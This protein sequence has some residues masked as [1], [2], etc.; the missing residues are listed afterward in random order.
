MK[1]RCERDV[2]LEAFNNAQRATS[3]RAALPALSGIRL[4][5]S[6]DELRVTGSDLDLTITTRVTVSGQEDGEVVLS[7]KLAVDIIRALDPGAVNIEASSERAHISS[8]RSNF[9]L[10]TR[11]ADEYP[12]LADIEGE[13]MTIAAQAFEDGLKQVVRA[14]SSDDSRPILT[15]VL[16]AAEAE[17][18]RMVATDS[19]RLAVR[20]LPSGTA[21]LRE[22]ES[23]L[24]PSRALS[25]LSR[26]MKQAE[27]IVLVLG[28]RDASFEAGSIRLTT[29]LIEGDFPNYRGLI[30]QSQP[31]QLTVDRL[32]FLDAVRRVRLMA[33]EGSPIRVNLSSESVELRATNVEMGEASEAV[34]A[35][36]VG[37]EITVAFNPDYLIDGIEIT[38]G[39]EITLNTVDELKP[40]LIRPVGD[41]ELLYLLMPVRV[42]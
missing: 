8:G 16:I 15:G 38:P 12:T 9:E 2:L 4:Q 39:D 24:V 10:N 33:Q 30:P 26:I 29:R 28:Q 11:P 18:V 27:E 36:Y 14:A 22:G 3:S 21:A 1:F 6:G 17:G 40:A 32:A 7:A 42:S 20:D 41:D 34:D 13:R 25:E 5:L 31:N 19:Y 23:V 37:D 35:V